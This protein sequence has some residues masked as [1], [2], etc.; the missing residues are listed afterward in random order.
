MPI[1]AAGFLIGALAL[2]GIP[3]LNGFI[4][5]YLILQAGFQKGGFYPALSVLLL[6]LTFAMFAAYVKVFQRVF[7]RVEQVKVSE[8]SYQ[9]I[10]IIIPIIILSV[11]CVLMGVFPTAIV[12]QINKLSLTILGG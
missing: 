6:V 10:Y 1:V 4:S 2:S 7:F 5:E 11:L 3:P 8:V 12:D 9:S